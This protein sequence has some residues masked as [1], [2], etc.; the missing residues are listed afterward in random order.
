MAGLF[1]GETGNPKNTAASDLNRTKGAGIAAVAGKVPQN[2]FDKIIEWSR[3][4]EPRL[5]SREQFLY[6][7]NKNMGEIAGGEFYDYLAPF[8][9]PSLVNYKPT[10]RE[11]QRQ[12]VN[13][14][15]FA[16]Y[17]N[18]E[19]VL[20]MEDFGDVINNGIY[21]SVNYIRATP[22]NTLSTLA[23][24]HADIIETCCNA[25]GVEPTPEILDWYRSID[26]NN[27]ILSIS[28]I[29]Y[30]NMNKHFNENVTRQ[31]EGICSKFPN[32]RNDANFIYNLFGDG[33]KTDFDIAF[34]AEKFA[35]EMSAKTEAGNLFPI[36]LG[37]R[38]KAKRYEELRHQGASVSE[39]YI[40]SDLDS[41]R[42]VLTDTLGQFIPLLGITGGA[43][44]SLLEDAEDVFRER[45]EDI[46]WRN[47][48]KE[49]LYGL[50]ITAASESIAGV[51][52][53]CS[54]VAA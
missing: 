36:V 35:D 48:G 50:F 44:N 54:L 45:K 1:G 23:K 28:R 6:N 10:P 20:N 14:E 11:Q 12:S 32:L 7:R 37:L 22:V 30:D 47:A 52:V 27:D 41:T 26:D 39:A 34:F 16:N 49:L 17:H 21:A 18:G 19:T 51:K 33:T 25:A 42:G 53:I 15:V 4:G 8:R 3:S 38:T 24:R 31:I 13:D 29:Q 5:S 46:N 40:Q 43:V 2:Y 9:D